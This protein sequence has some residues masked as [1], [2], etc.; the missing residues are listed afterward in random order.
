[1]NSVVSYKERDNIHRL[2]MI[3]K[4][5]LQLLQ[6]QKRKGEDMKGKLER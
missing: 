3:A 5:N 2:L 1:M 6:G 4:L